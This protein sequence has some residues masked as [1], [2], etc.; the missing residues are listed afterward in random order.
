MDEN[1]QSNADEIGG[2]LKRVNRFGKS[3]EQVFSRLYT[4]LSRRSRARPDPLQ[5][6]KH[7]QLLQEKIGQVKRLSEH[8]RHLQRSL[9]KRESEIERLNGVLASID[10]GIIMQD[11]EGRIVLINAA[12][13]A[14]LGKHKNFW[15]SE[16]GTLFDEHRDVTEVDAELVPLGEPT[17]IQVNHT[18]LG[19]QLA[20]VGDSAGRRLG[21]M[22]VLRDVTREALAERLKNEFVLNISHE[23]NTPMTAIKG[24]AELLA[25]Q[26][27]NQAVNRR[28]LG[29]LTRNVDVL[30]R[31]VV[32][33]LDLSELE[34]GDFNIR[35][36]SL[37]IETMVWRV[38]SGRTPEIKRAR[39]DVKVMARDVSQLRITG[40]EERLMWALGH[41]VQNSIR[42]TEPDQ[43]ITI[44]TRLQNRDHIAIS[45]K[46]TG[47]GIAE[48]D[49]PHIFDRFYR[50]EP[51]SPDG[52]LL[53]PRGLGQGLYVARTV[54]EAHQGYLSVDSQPGVGS[55]FTLILPATRSNAL[56]DLA[57]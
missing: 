3:T 34:T 47:V 46:D 45:V 6:E 18:I 7:Q 50:G 19:A 32:E 9:E 35:R 17:Q 23:L 40:D 12:A 51:R 13:Q 24:A 39:L 53:D 22:I 10:E 1:P 14:L 54:A 30:N 20:A 38:V 11:I 21:T 36:D 44:S 15:E 8:N 52:R 5:W 16:I 56:P 41:L 33:L 27:E 26:P 2:V 4:G 29:L 31:M 28:Y 42:Y 25:G 37:L 55:T 57:S 43:H 48:K 49:M